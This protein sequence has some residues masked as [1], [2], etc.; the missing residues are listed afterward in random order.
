MLGGNPVVLK[1][2]RDQKL[3]GNL[4]FLLVGVTGKLDDLHPIRQGRRHRV[5][6]IRG[7]NKQDIGKIERQIQ[8]MIAEG[9]ILFRVQDLE[10]RRRRIAAKVRADFVDLIEHEHGIVRPGLFDPLDDAAGKRPH[11][12]APVAAHFRFVAHAA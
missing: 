5:Q 8:V 6:Q 1:L 10:Q 9:M 4:Q 11:V 7:A 12:G 3:A 2:A